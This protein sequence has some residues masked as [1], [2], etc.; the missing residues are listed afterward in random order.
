MAV[1]NLSTQPGVSWHRKHL[2]QSVDTVVS[3]W[4]LNMLCSRS[5]TI[6]TFIQDG[7][8]IR[9]FFVTSSKSLGFV[10]HKQN[11]GVFAQT[12]KKKKMSSS[13]NGAWP[14][15]RA[16]DYQIWP[17]ARLWHPGF[18]T[19]KLVIRFAQSPPPLWV[20]VCGGGFHRLV[21]RAGRS[22][23]GS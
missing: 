7:W 6:S 5:K 9:C 3:V 15:Q 4:L 8:G 16:H 17:K 1:L 13:K 10:I 21:P 23:S 19:Q 12:T 18:L 22:A 11:I 20:L 14:P 2:T